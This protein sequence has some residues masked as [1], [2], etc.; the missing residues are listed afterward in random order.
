MKKV[1]ARVRRGVF[2]VGMAAALSLQAADGIWGRTDNTDQVNPAAW[3]NA[4]NWV[5]GVVAGDGGQAYFTN[6]FPNLAYRAVEVPPEGVTLNRF[7]FNN[8]DS[9]TTRWNGAYLLVSGGP[10]RM[11]GMGGAAPRLD[12]YSDQLWILS[13]IQGTN[14]LTSKPSY[15]VN[16]FA[17]SS[18]TGL[19][20]IES[21]YW[22]TRFDG[23]V[24]SADPVLRDYA[25]TNDFVLTGGRLSFYGRPARTAAVTSNWALVEGTTLATFVSGSNAGTITPG[26]VVTGGG[27]PGGTFVRRIINNTNIQLSEAAPAGGNPVS[28]AFSPVA[29]ECYQTI[30]SVDSRNS[31]SEFILNKNSANVLR[32][33]VGELKGSGNVLQRVSPGQPTGV[34]SLHNTRAYG[35]LYSLKDAWLELPKDGDVQPTLSNLTVVTA[36]TLD[37]PGAD[38]VAS[39]PSLGGVTNTLTKVGAGRLTAGLGFGSSLSFAVQAGS[40]ELP[41]PLAASLLAEASLRLDASR[42]DTLTLDAEGRVSRWGD[43]DGRANGVTNPVTARQPLRAEN[44][45]NGLPAIDFGPYVG[46]SA[47]CGLFLEE[48]KTNVVS[49]FIVY[50]GRTTDAV[51]FGEAPGVSACAYTRSG[52]TA[53]AIWSANTAASV[54]DGVT[55][56]DGIKVSGT[57]TVLQTNEF[58]LVSVVGTGISTVGALGN[59][60][61][62]RSGGQQVAEVILFDRVL[63]LA[64]QATVDAYLMEKWFGSLM[65]RQVAGLTLAHGTRLVLPYAETLV[66]SNLTLLGEVWLEGPGQVLAAGG[67]TQ[68]GTVHFANGGGLAVSGME[69]SLAPAEPVVAESPSFWVDACALTNAGAA[70]VVVENGTNFVTRWNDVR[71]EGYNYATNITL[72]PRLRLNDING[73]PSVYFARILNVVPSLSEALFWNQPMNDIRAVFMVVGSQEGGGILLG[74][75][76]A[77]NTQDFYRNAWSDSSRTIFNASGTGASAALLNGLFCLNGYAV[78]PAATSYNGFFQ[79]VEAYPTGPVKAS[80]FA[81]DRNIVNG[82]G[83]QRICEMILYNRVLSEQEKLNTAEYLMRKWLGRGVPRAVAVSGVST[84]AAEGGG[85][86]GVTS[87]NDFISVGCYTGSGDV[88]KAGGGTLVLNSI[89]IAGRKLDVQAGT[90]VLKAGDPAERVPTDAFLHVDAAAANAFSNV[91]INGTNFVESWWHADG[92]AVYA[93]MRN[94]AARVRPHVLTNALNGLPVVEFGPLLTGNPVNAIQCFLE[95][96]VAG[97]D[98]ACTNLRDAFVVIGS[99]A[100]GNTILGTKSNPR[101]FWRDNAF[102]ASLLSASYAPLHLRLGET[103]R[104][105]VPVAPTSVGLSGGY[106][107]VSFSTYPGGGI[108]TDGFAIDAYN[109]TGGQRLGEVLIFDR[110]L[111]YQERLDIE[112][113]LMRKWFNVATPGY[114]TTAVGS[115]AVAADARVEIDGELSLDGLSG[116]G[117]VEGDLTLNDDA[118]ITATAAS[119]A[120]SGLTV[121]GTVTVAGGGTVAVEGAADTLTSGLYAVLTCTSLVGADG[122]LAGWTLTGAPS[123]F[124]AKLVADGS[125]LYLRLTPKGTLMLMQ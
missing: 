109:R 99:Q 82:N 76:A 62:Y 110:A 84:V 115:L 64:E 4:A 58:H 27:L 63:T 19:T 15:S 106:D 96:E 95:F 43:A 7:V 35:G 59:D 30:R 23:V 13:E 90:L 119:G 34:L 125:H 86:L 105:G 5:G 31:A 11:E 121:G 42:A 49:A 28:L 91:V 112:A 25:S 26:A 75:S 71:G 56:L 100:G 9:S 39:V 97:V 8:Y 24:N 22:I 57:A 10:M 3:T 32:V 36:S 124:A 50:Y 116:G 2:A 79:L 20:T 102:S 53:N 41:R 111:T 40:L 104:N 83:C 122:W 38:T 98:V 78:N 94:T 47:G 70:G 74:S 69:G 29:S 52:N 80:A 103:R 108:Y 18:Y 61:N 46:S 60:R 81:A 88:V 1:Q 72:R 85:T 51:I 117:T 48:R 66:V 45:L 14:G 67:L 55:D 12:S 44:A 107:L 73:L 16:I 17:D 77:E 87:T 113:Y 54:K 33:D 37:V 123:R 101:Q 65:K 68:S 89:D 93:T 120:L 21:D 118:V 6:A 92:G 114:E